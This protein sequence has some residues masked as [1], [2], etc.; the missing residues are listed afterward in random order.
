MELEQIISSLEAMDPA[1]RDRAIKMAMEQTK[2]MAW[3]PNPGPQTTAYFNEA[4]ELFYG[5]QA[6]G[7]KTDLVCGLALNEHQFSLLLRR[8]NKEASLLAERILAIKGDREGWN[9]QDHVL[10]L[11]DSRRVDIGG[12]QHD[13]D[14]QKYKGS[15]HD[16]IAFDEVSDFAESQYRFIIGWNRTT[17]PGQRCRVVATGNPPTRPEGFWVLRYWGAWVDPNHPNP[18]QPGELRW[19]TT[20]A[21]EDHE[22]DGRG[23]HLVKGEKIVKIKSTASLNTKDMADYQKD[24]EIWAK[25]YGFVFN[26][27]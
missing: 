4:D 9:G 3:R 19:Y 7:G 25:Q 21:G 15:P 12:V 10:R 18:A 26:D 11:A 24:I 23:P 5:G 14:E 27:E 6:G 1:S 20:I 17:S 2:N 16:L 22:V 13:G 8:T